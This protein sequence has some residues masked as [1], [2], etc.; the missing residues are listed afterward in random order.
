[1][2]YI[3]EENFSKVNQEILQFRPKETDFLTFRVTRIWVFR[4]LIWS[5]EHDRKDLVLAT[6]S[7]AVLNNQTTIKGRGRGWRLKGM[8]LG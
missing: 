2:K 5:A 3:F 7:F 6:P 4:W 1:M 8:A